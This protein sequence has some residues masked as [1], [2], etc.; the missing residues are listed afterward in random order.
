MAHVTSTNIARPQPDPGGSARV[1]GIDKRPAAGIEVSAPG[2]DYGDGSGVAGDVIGDV[3]HHGGADKA[4]YAFARE[5]LDWWE[6]QLGRTLDDGT[7]GE[8]LTTSGIDWAGALL[9]QRFRVGEAVLQVSVPRSPCRTFAG[10][11]GEPGWVKRFAASGDC[12]SYLRVLTPGVIRPGDPITALDEP[13]HGRTMGQA[14]AAVM[15]DWEAARDLWERRL[16]PPR[17]RARWDA[18]FGPA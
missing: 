1:S 17:Y 4:V 10:W 16:L 8:N 7:F 5:R 6:G 2:P 11:L 12:G 18:R 14:F 3:A 15:G 13:D 9:D